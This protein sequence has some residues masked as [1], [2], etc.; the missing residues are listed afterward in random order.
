MAPAPPGPGIVAGA[1]RS[2]DGIVRVVESRELTMLFTDIEG[3]TRLLNRLGPRFAD[4]LAAHRQVLRTAFRQWGG[5]ELGTEGDSFFVVFDSAEDA[6]A[7][8]VAGQLGL[9]RHAWPDDVRLRVRMGLHTGHPEEFEDDLTGFDVH[10]AARISATGHGGQVVLSAATVDRLTGHLPEGTGLIG[11]GVHRLKDIPE[12]QRLW[13]L[14]VDGLPSSFPPLRSLGA[15]G[16]LPTPPTPFVGRED[17]LAAVAGLLREDGPRLVT[18]T[19]PGGA[20]KTRLALAVARSVSGGYAD[21]VHFADLASATEPGDAWAAL[22]EALGRPGD[23]EPVLLDHLASQ[24]ALLLLDTPERLPDCGA[25]VVRRLLEGTAAPRLLVTSRRPLHVPG[26]QVYPVMPMGLPASGPAPTVASAGATDAVRMFVQHATL[27]DPSF[28]LTEDNV[29]DV[30]AV[31]RHLDGLPLALELVAAQVRLLPPR[32]LAEH[33]DEALGLPSGGRPDRQRS[34][35]DTVEWSYGMVDAAGQRAFRALSVFGTSGGSFEALCEVLDADSVLALVA[36]LL[37]AAL[38]RVDDAGSGR[39]VRA[40]QPVR[41]VARRLLDGDGERDAFQHRHALHYAGLAERTAPGLNGPGAMAARAVL[42]LERDNL[43]AALD[44]S[45]GDGPG[46]DGR[47]AVPGGAAGD[48]PAAAVP[49]RA[50]IGIR[51][52]TALGWHWYATGF[53][54]ER[55][56][57]LELASRA[58]SAGQGPELARLL[59]S[60]GLLLLQHGDLTRARDVLAKSLVLARRAGDRTQEAVVLNSLGVAHRALGDPDR[61]RTLLRESVDV[62]ESLGNLP[63]QATALT[64]LALLELDTGHADAAI[65]LL[66][67]A[68][69]IDGE[70]ED[71]WGVAADRTN[72]SAALLVAG[73]TGEAVALLRELAATVQDHGDP[74]LSLGVVELLAVAAAQQ[75]QAERAVVLAATAAEQRRR[76]HLTV[77]EP[78]REFLD[79][80]LAGSRRAVGDRRERLEQQGRE[81]DVAA[82]LA[83]AERLAGDGPA[84]Q[85]EVVGGA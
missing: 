55:R 30:V 62:A 9:E 15:P 43:R 46:G 73:R 24:H 50:V 14:T 71:A 8:A 63:R 35:A 75:G 20:G 49:D 37:D 79:R 74:D 78:D 38:V 4:V 67:R 16:G 44:W 64:N 22:G 23:V 72:L 82:A 54:D 57:W 27:S 77:A 60:F 1:A 13:Q 7:A 83:E 5:R 31:C 34:L 68:E 45:L 65:D 58:A 59:Q 81:L 52:C 29:A 61:A 40:L 41:A 48:R 32:L 3:S 39:R 17:D 80:R 51:L 33:L 21:G 42:D 53:D 11:L 47:G 10:L 84:A 26:E 12:P 18:L 56:R 76:A 2:E 85:R 66:R 6:A 70:L 25:P 19:G 69:G 36:G 28:A